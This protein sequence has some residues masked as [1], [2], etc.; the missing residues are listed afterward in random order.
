MEI[1][2][3]ELL[4]EAAIGVGV[5]LSEEQTDKFVEIKHILQIE[6]QKFNLTGIKD[7]L[8]IAVKHFADSLTLLSIPGVS[9]CGSFIDIGTGAGFP[10]I[11]LAVMLPDAKGLL[12]DSVGKKVRFV[13]QMAMDLGITN[14]KTAIGRAEE[15][16]KLPQHREKYGMAVVRGVS[17]LYIRGVRCPLP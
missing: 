3:R 1:Q 16:A 15:L 12:V 10:G 9:E 5:K 7:D 11:V 4:Y 8:G 13:E 2:F 6:S 14:A 17:S